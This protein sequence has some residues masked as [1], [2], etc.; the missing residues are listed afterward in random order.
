MNN[1]ILVADKMHESL[2][3]MLA[4][5]GCQCDYR[6]AITRPEILAILYEYSGLIIRSKTA[7]DQELLA[8]GPALKFVGRA[9]AGVDQLDLQA[10]ESR[11]IAVFNAP[12][13]NRDA[14]G[15]HCVG[16]LLSLLHKLHGADRQVRKMIW[17]REV[18]RGIEL[19]G[20]TVGIFGFGFMGSSFAEKLQGFEC[21]VIAYDKYKTKYGSEGV[22]HV[23][24]P[25]FLR[26]TE[27]LSIHVPLTDETR[28]LVTSEWLKEF[29]RLFLLINSSRGEI[30]VL[31]DILK[32]LQNEIL[33]GAGLDVLENEKLANLTDNQQRVFHELKVMEQVIFTPHVAGWTHESYQRINE[34]LVDK[35]SS[36]RIFT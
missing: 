33:L 15:E 19:K 14:V 22:R 5:I 13:G 8:Y 26:E 32:S 3:S 27:I 10:L 11:G 16:M 12:E 24:L 20:K 25:T 4:S 6:P 31:G 9:G 2:D 18:N 23:D 30:V 28:G 36:A 34:V 21:E 17:D 29:D 35:I 1:R 7:V